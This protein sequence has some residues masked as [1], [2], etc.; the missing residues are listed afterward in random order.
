MI[1][2]QD[3]YVGE[4]W[5]E[6]AQGCYATW[7][8]EVADWEGVARNGGATSA[9]PPV[10]P[11]PKNLDKFSFQ[12]PTPPIVKP[13]RKTQLA[14]AKR[15]EKEL[16]QQSVRKVKKEKCEEQVAMG[17]K[18]ETKSK[19]TEFKSKKGKKTKKPEKKPVKSHSNGPMQAAKKDF[20]S[21]AKRQGLS[22]KES[23]QAWGESEERF[24]IVSS[25]SESER[26]RRRY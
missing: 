19:K 5:P 14:A 16:K 10:T 2:L 21:E 24:A 6:Q 25:M 9:S 11:A 8:Q 7:S 22:Y 26:K 1:D 17:K 12:I 3:G 13:Y 4:L 20:M 18:T 15:L 23:L